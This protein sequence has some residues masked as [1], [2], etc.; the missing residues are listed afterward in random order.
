MIYSVNHSKISIFS[1]VICFFI[2][3][4]PT[5]I[6]AWEGNLVGGMSFDQSKEIY[7]VEGT[8][9]VDEIDGFEILMHTDLD[10]QSTAVMLIK[11]L[12]SALKAE[13]F[14]WGTQN[15]HQAQ[16]SYHRY[17]ALGNTLE[18]FD[19]LKG[20]MWVELKNE[21]TL[22]LKF[23]VQENDQR[24]WTD[25]L[26][27][28]KIGASRP[29]LGVVEYHTS[30]QMPTHISSS[31]SDDDSQSDDACDCGNSTQVGLNQYAGYSAGSYGGNS[32]GSYG[33][34]SAGSYAGSYAGT[35]AGSSGNY[36]GGS[37][38]SSGNSPGTGSSSGGSSG[39]SSGTSST[40]DSSDDSCSDDDGST[41]SDSDSCSSDSSDDSSASMSVTSALLDFKTISQI[42]FRYF[43]WLQRKQ[44][45][46]PLKK[47]KQLPYYHLYLQIFKLLPMLS[48][49]LLIFYLKRSGIKN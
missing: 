18:S 39:L 30:N 25:Q 34:N 28:V 45:H 11:A 49:A 27:L 7:C 15:P 33:G 24:C 3:L 13:R 21:D 32:A 6:C 20:W 14:E 35:Y 22:S 5:V 46:Q 9:E 31:Q 44:I 23:D 12:G 2:I 41:S 48:V 19:Q 29:D 16:F 42:S 26:Y 36:S 8:G 37:S 1:V 40:S 4:L 38:N 47:Y 17:D 43:K 10:D